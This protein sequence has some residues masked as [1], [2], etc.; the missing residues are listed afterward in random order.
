[1]MPPELP[2][3]PG[4]IVQVGARVERVGDQII[5]YMNF[6]DRIVAGTGA[7][8]EEATIDAFQTAFPDK[9]IQRDPGFRADLIDIDQL[10]EKVESE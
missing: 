8:L 1:M 6:G 10:T 2:E 4:E 9:E 3:E 7:T 5:V